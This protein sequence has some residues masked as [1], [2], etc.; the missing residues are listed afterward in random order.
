[1]ITIDLSRNDERPLYVRVYESIKNDIESGKI[2]PEEKLPSK[3][4]LAEHLNV[5]VI[6]IQNAYAQ[7]IA[8]GYIRAEERRGFFAADLSQF[9]RENRKFEPESRLSESDERKKEE[10]R[11]DISS[12]YGDFRQFPFSVWTNKMRHV[13]SE[14][15]DS[16]LNMVPN[17]GLW[18]LR[19]AISNYL[20]KF[21]GI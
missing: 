5:S 9:I 2:A 14:N 3:R 6:T 11:I 21:R 15:Y 4:A 16:I 7:L 8:E 12:V 17:K 13:I 18:E 19:V 20:Y 10:L 1:M